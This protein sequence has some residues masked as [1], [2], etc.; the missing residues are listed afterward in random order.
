M[1]EDDKTPE[2]VETGNLDNMSD[3]ELAKARGDFIE[4][5]T[6]DTEQQ[7]APEGQADGE[8]GSDDGEAEGLPPEQENPE[9]E[10]GSEAEDSGEDDGTGKQDS[11]L[12]EKRPPIMIPKSRL[13]AALSR[14]R[15]AEAKLAEYN[16]LP[17]QQQEQVSQQPV[18]E[19]RNL[20]AELAELD[21]K[22]AEA[23][24][25]GTVDD[26]PSLLA[27]Q[28]KLQNEYMSEQIRANTVDPVAIQQAT[29]AELEFDVLLAQV[30]AVRPETDPS[31]DNEAYDE[32]LV[33]E[34][35]DL[36][37]A[38]MSRGASKIDA[39][40][41][42]L[43]YVYPEGWDIQETTTESPPEPVAE[44]KPAP[45]PKKTDM[46]RNIEDASKL[47][48]EMVQGDK[49]S[50]AGIKEK[51]NPMKLTD[52]QFEKLTDEQLAE[53]RGDNYVPPGM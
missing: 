42:A 25:D 35:N 50:D 31:E 9:I 1:A 19:Q 3:E 32:A 10:A 47:A 53:L 4:E 21:A 48:P 45:S 6:D 30:E 52:E 12:E 27:E 8:S 51:I 20:E 36:M 39:L 16:S 37:D 15:E 26:L 11:P 29:R 7:S 17:P 13:D 40:E 34:V 43:G 41:R 28:R 49:S 44:T 18:P 14:A 24:A 46:K 22:M 33:A 5:E 2:P 23:I 38:F